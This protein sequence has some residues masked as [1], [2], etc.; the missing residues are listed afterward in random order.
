LYYF[1]TLETSHGPFRAAWGQDSDIYLYS[2][3]DESPEKALGTIPASDAVS[4]ESIWKSMVAK[5]VSHLVTSYD[6]FEIHGVTRAVRQ[7]L[8]LAEFF[9][10]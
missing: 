10:L 4:S 7:R 5:S 6:H 3:A 1:I 8:S 2:G 9:S